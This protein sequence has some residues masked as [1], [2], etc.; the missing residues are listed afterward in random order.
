MRFFQKTKT[1]GAIRLFDLYNTRTRLLT[2]VIMLVCVIMVVVSLF[3]M[4]WAVLAGF[5]TPVELNQSTK[6]LPESFDFSGYVKSWTDLGFLKYYRNSAIQILGGVFCAVLFNGL[7][8]YSLAILKPK[9]SKVV[10]A[11][12]MWCMLIPPTT[13][14]VAL[15]L[16]I[17]R[18][19]LAIESITGT[20]LI[21]TAAG[22]V[23]LWLMMGANAFWVILFK[24]FFE[25]LP[26][27][28]IE[29][30]QLDGCSNL[31]VFF[32]IV[33]PM[34]KPIIGVV[35]MF[36]IT[37]AWSD[38]LLPYLMLNNSDWSTVMVRLF[39]FRSDIRTTSSDVL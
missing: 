14:I 15:Y 21:G 9:G 26:R 30:A 31:Q 7:L 2:I 4:A 16:N 34:S 17:N 1:E 11:L 8:A 38:F 39:A 37:A 24:Q 3:P 19:F 12:V 36:A 23:P 13:S 10:F 32:R 33:L 20:K 6:F 28:Y 29:A 25:R 18:T 22:F 27:E 5:K 35:V